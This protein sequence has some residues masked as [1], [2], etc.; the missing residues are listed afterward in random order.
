MSHSQFNSPATL[1]Q[2]GTVDVSGPLTVDP[3]AA[4]KDVAFR[5]LIVQDSV[6]AKGDGQGEGPGGGIGIWRGTAAAEPGSLHAGDSTLALA[7]AVVAKE[8]PPGLETFTW[9]QQIELQEG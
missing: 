7:L 1:H 6:V 5:F 3:P 2:N 8:D 9:S 4:L